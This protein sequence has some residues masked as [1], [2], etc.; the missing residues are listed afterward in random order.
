MAVSRWPKAGARWRKLFDG[1]ITVAPV[2]G[3][4]CCQLRYGVELRLTTV[5]LF[6]GTVHIPK[7]HGPPEERGIKGMQ[8]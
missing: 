1:L 5:G 2:D 8:Y 7:G 3:G 4:C 6:R